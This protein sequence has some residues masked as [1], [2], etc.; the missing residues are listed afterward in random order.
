MAQGPSLVEKLK[1]EINRIENSK[2]GTSEKVRYTRTETTKILSL[3]FTIHCYI[4]FT[5]SR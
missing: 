5:G 1:E 4:S 2:K 3:M